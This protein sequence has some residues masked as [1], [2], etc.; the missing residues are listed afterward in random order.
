MSYIESFLFVN[1][2]K[3]CTPITYGTGLTLQIRNFARFAYS[4]TLGEHAVLKFL[5]S[6]PIQV[7]IARFKHAYKDIISSGS[8]D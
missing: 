8:K 7:L 2:L 6:F 5:I 1:I 3:V 4:V